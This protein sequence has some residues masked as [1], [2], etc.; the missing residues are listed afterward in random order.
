MIKQNV[1]ICNLTVFQT[2]VL[3]S[4]MQYVR[5]GT[6]GTFNQELSDLSDILEEAQETIGFEPIQIDATQDDLPDS[7]VLSILD[8]TLTLMI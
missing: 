6:S 5:L 7:V 4:L 8:P 2:Q 3:Y 1:N